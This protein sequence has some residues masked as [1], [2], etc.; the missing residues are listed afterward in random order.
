MQTTIDEFN[1]CIIE[2]LLTKRLPYFIQ[3][4]GRLL[5][6]LSSEEED[7]L[8]VR[9]VHSLENDLCRIFRDIYNCNVCIIEHP[10]QRQHPCIMETN[11]EKFQSLG[12]NVLL[13]VDIEAL[14]TSF[15]NS[16]DFVSER[17]LKNISV[18]GTKDVLLKSVK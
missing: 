6:I 10:S 14:A 8:M 3:C 18:K 15:V 12:D 1:K 7:I 4:K 17:F 16:N 9:L 5:A 2:Y 13:M 11:L